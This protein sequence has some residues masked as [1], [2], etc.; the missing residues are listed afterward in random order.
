VL[1]RNGSSAVRSRLNHCRAA[2]VVASSLHRC[3]QPAAGTTVGATAANATTITTNNN[4]NTTTTT[5]NATSTTIAAS[6]SPSRSTVRDDADGDQNRHDDRGRDHADLPV[7]TLVIAIIGCV[8][9][10][11]RS[12]SREFQSCPWTIYANDA[13]SR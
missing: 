12:G 1:R 7:A 4:N 13:A 10:F 5:R 8:H 11:M 6:T 2:V 3:S 9:T